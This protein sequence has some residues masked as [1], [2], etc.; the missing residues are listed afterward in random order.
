M[1]GSAMARAIRN[2]V[3]LCRFIYQNLT[4]VGATY[5]PVA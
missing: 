1:I 5:M 4:P 2:A 3:N